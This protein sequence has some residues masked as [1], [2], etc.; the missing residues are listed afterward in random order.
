[1]HT[2]RMP[3]VSI[4]GTAGYTGQET[5]DRVLRHPELELYAVGSDSLARRGRDRARPAAQPER[6]QACPA[7]DHERRRARVRGRR[8]VPLPLA[9]GGRGIRAAVARR[10]DRPLGR[11]PARRPVAVRGVVR[12]HASPSRRARRV[13]VRAARAVAARGQAGRQPRLLRVRSCSR[14]PSGSFFDPDCNS[15]SCTA[16]ATS[17]R[18]WCAATVNGSGTSPNRRRAN[19]YMT[20]VSKLACFGDTGAMRVFCVIPVRRDSPSMCDS[21]RRAGD[22]GALTD[23]ERT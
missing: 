1:M 5:L 3:Y 14:T 17:S 16:L 4:V 23:A 10:R 8:D 20:R 19:R 22:F 9:R 7:A 21:A 13:V 6:R 15:V 18:G 11:P 12:L 2:M